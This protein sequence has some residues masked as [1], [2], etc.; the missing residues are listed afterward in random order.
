MASHSIINA[1]IN[2][3]NKIL[4]TTVGECTVFSTLQDTKHSVHGLGDFTPKHMQTYGH[5]QP[6]GVGRFSVP[7]QA[8]SRCHRGKVSTTL[9]RLPGPGSWYDISLM[10]SSR[11]DNQARGWGGERERDTNICHI[12]THIYTYIYN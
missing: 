1:K 7:Q 11:E 10:N 8:Q 9:F 3:K 5:L 12:Y 2:L 4:L 6:G